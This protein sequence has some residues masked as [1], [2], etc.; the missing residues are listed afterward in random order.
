VVEVA[1]RPLVAWSLAAFGSAAG[2]GRAI[3]AAPPGRETEIRSL[4]PDGLQ[5]DVVEGGDTRVESVANAL[6]AVETELVVVHD[7]ARPLVTTELIEA[8]LA[9]LEARPDAAGVIAAAPL[10]DT[11]KRAR[12]PRPEKGEFE[13]GGPTISKT[14]S[15]DHLWAAQTPQAFRTAALREAHDADAQRLAA[16]TDDAMLVEKSGGKVLIEPAPAR[17]LKVTTPDDLRLAELLLG[18]PSS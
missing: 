16:A 13:R 18:Q 6:A 9:K 12:E 4:A 7:A 5:L 14:E 8:V 15:R 3:V 11:V 2:I 17:N 1:G 10:T